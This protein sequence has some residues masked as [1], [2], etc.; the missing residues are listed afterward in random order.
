MSFRCFDIISNKPG[1]FLSD[2]CFV[3]VEIVVAW[4]DVQRRKLFYYKFKSIDK[5][6]F[7]NDLKSICQDLL[8]ID[9]L[10]ELAAKYNS[11]LFSLLKKHT[12]VKSKILTVHPI[13]PWFSP[14]IKNLKRDWRKAEMSW[15]SDMFTL[16]LIQSSR[17][18]G[19]DT[20]IH[21]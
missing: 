18:Q 2:H 14:T 5:P 6:S 4:L 1:Y 8:L 7:R 9:D 20:D 15:R 17:L 13:V 16:F 12:P 21:Y 10:N 19:I 3:C 11:R